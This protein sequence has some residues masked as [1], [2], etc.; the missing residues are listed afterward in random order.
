MAWLLLVAFV[1]FAT[2]DGGASE[3]ATLEPEILKLR[4]VNGSNPCAG[5]VEIFHNDTW[6]T[7]CDDYWDVADAVVVCRQMD[8]GFAEV[9]SGSASFGQGTEVIWLDDV[10]CYG[11]EASLRECVLKPI[12][13]HNCHHRED[14][15]VVCNREQPPKPRI[16]LSRFSDIF[17]KGENLF[18]QCSSFGFYKTAAFY[19]YKDDDVNHLASKP[20]SARGES[21]I[22]HYADINVGNEGNYSCSY[23]VEVSGRIYNSPKNH[24]AKP[25]ISL[26]PDILLMKG[27]SVDIV[28][29]APSYFSGA[30]F[31][32]YKDG[33]AN[34]VSS[35]IASTQLVRSHFKLH[36]IT[37][38]DEGNYTCAY[39]GDIVGKR[40]NSSHSDSIRVAVIEDV[41]M[42]LVNGEND[43]S[44]SVQVYFNDTWGS[45]CGEGWDLF[46]VQVVCRQLGCGFALGMMDISRFSN[47]QKPIWLSTVRCSSAEPYLWVCPARGWTGGMSCDRSR[48]A[49][50]TCTAQPPAP[51]MTVTGNGLFFKDDTITFV[52]TIPTLYRGAKMFLHRVG[53]EA[54]MM[55]TVS[56]RN[57]NNV[58]FELRN[59][60]QTHNGTYWCNYGFE[61]A[62]LH[63][64][65]QDSASQEITV[66]EN[67]K[68]R[69]VDGHEPCSGRVEAYY[70]GTWGT[71][72]DS[73]W[74]IVDA[75]VVCRQVG[76]G[77]GQS[78][79][80]GGLFGEGTGPILL[81]NVRCNGSERFL[82]SCPTQNI[83]P[84]TC[85]QRN[86]AG[87]IC[88][89]QL[90]SPEITVLRTSGIFAQGESLQ[91]K[92]AC[93]NYYV[94]ARFKLHKVGEATYM[95]S[96]EA[97]GEYSN[98]TFVVANITKGMAGYYTCTYQLLSGSRLYNSTM[99]DK[100]KVSVIEKPTK[101]DIQLFRDSGTYS[102][103]EYV[104]IRCSASAIFTGAIFHLLKA[105]GAGG[106]TYQ[107]VPSAGFAV[108]FS[109]ANLTHGDGGSYFCL[110]QLKRS[111]HL[112]NSTESERVKVTVTDNLLRP[113]ISVLRSSGAFIQ[114]E[115]VNFR[116]SSSSVFAVITFYLYKVGE[117]GSITSV[118]PISVSSSILTIQN[119]SLSQD[120][121][122]T[123][124]FKV[125]ISGKTYASTHSDRVQI[126]IASRAEQPT[127]SKN[128]E[129]HL[130]PQGQL[131]TLLC[132][133][134]KEYRTRNFQLYQN[135]QELTTRMTVRDSVAEFT[136]VNTTM[137]N[138]GE[139]TCAYRTTIAGREYN[140]TPSEPLTITISEHMDLQL[141][142]GSHPCEGRVEIS[143]G[144]NWGTVCD[145]QWGLHDAKV[146]CAALGC[147][148]ANSA[149]SHAHFG[150]GSGPIWL[151]DVACRGDES[152]LWY[153]SARLWGSHNCHHGEDA[154]VIC[155]G[156]R[157]T[158]ELVPSYKVFLNGES[159][160][161]NC[162]IWE[163]NT[164]RGIDFY[165]NGSFLTHR[166]IRPGDN[167]AHLEMVNVTLKD[168]GTYGCKYGNQLAGD[169]ANSSLDTSA[170]ITVTDP[171]ETPQIALYTAGGKSLINCTVRNEMPSG[172]MY[173]L[174]VGGG[175]AQR[176]S[177][178]NSTSTF[179]LNESDTQASAR[180]VC[181]YQLR[182][183]GRALNSTYT[184]PV[185]V[186]ASATP[187]VK[188]IIGWF[189]ATLILL[190][191]LVVSIYYFRKPKAF[192]MKR[193]YRIYVRE[194]LL[195]DV[196]HIEAIDDD[197]PI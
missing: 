193:K 90:Q 85:R 36:A 142:N 62:E 16:S 115:A 167:S 23:E 178:W 191:I 20:P 59:I 46:D 14:A 57:L 184:D 38:D 24:L 49:T 196:T 29:E 42:R 73:G 148:S 64:L 82:W 1:A 48:A 168:S 87:V 131:L 21:V 113:S 22:F 56:S 35:N 160:D 166:A 194:R 190:L 192:S 128:T 195:D 124:M 75:Q 12:G 37:K 63:F 133:A 162:T 50:V 107:A 83:M 123:C 145:D 144:D 117:S 78:A 176:M 45:V 114:G 97:E 152:V 47:I 89:N 26:N 28:C 15:G 106:V 189:L 141:V 81:D 172:V 112:Y 179:L 157:P 55:T 6:G 30:R 181:L 154:G 177:L 33:G 43:C 93:P 95:S 101:P 41:A 40:F 18:I 54:P 151:D 8:C 91:I 163:R 44:G 58:R 61:V 5:R 92:C 136:I 77:F 7:V 127:I 188:K 147:G 3:A 10:K 126:V 155:S 153:C 88:T 27:Q 134:P 139:Y 105:G 70:N 173:L 65:S 118:G 165:F 31:Y 19:L 150:R 135:S 109:I 66:V 94:G 158:M 99:S 17:V 9:A 39:Q 11:T 116:C 71:V 132:A 197:T 121:F 51:A 149:P 161:V 186:A 156:V 122:F 104:S 80:S 187:N 53:E 13:Q 137:A 164:S 169:H 185:L 84:R 174:A 67:A 120:G 108:T 79:T 171:P 34:F 76:C 4:L 138:Q 100:A 183:N 180:Y 96:L 182:L 98:V 86:D 2:E 102:I 119:I 146:V 111:G 72:C 130:Y 140:S 103:G 159:F 170:F 175:T 25:A 74:G 110:Y 69:L 143:F 68:L 32:L 125:L 52:C 60:N 129:F